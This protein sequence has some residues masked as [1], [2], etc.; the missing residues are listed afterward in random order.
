MFCPGRE[1]REATQ[2]KVRQRRPGGLAAILG[3][4]WR[5]FGSSW[6][7]FRAS[8]VVLGWSWSDLEGH[9][10]ARL[11]SNDFSVD[12]GVVLG[13]QKGAQIIDSKTTPKRTKIDHDFEH[14]KSTSSRPSWGPLGLISGLS[15]DDLDLKIVRWLQRRSL[16]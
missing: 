11:F 6:G 16:F 10:A 1:Q 9:L 12:V 13:G 7:V 5:I 14:R 2:G 15:W 3:T 8:W 4:S